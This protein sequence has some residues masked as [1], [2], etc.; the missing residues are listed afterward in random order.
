MT[1]LLK[2]VPL[3]THFLD[4]WDFK[5]VFTEGGKFPYRSRILSVKRSYVELLLC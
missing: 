3:F 1:A 5:I 4:G 2:R